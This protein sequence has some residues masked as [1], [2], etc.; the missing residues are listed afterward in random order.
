[1][2]VLLFRFLFL[3]HL[4]PHAIQVPFNSF[5]LLWVFFFLFFSPFFAG[6]FWNLILKPWLCC[7]VLSFSRTFLRKHASR[8]EVSLHKDF[9]VNTQNSLANNWHLNP[10][11]ESIPRATNRGRGHAPNIAL[12]QWFLAIKVVARHNIKQTWGYCKLYQRL[13]F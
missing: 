8:M 5:T 10:I 1:M 11:L 7:I 9:K 12:S 3:H 4:K 6:I 13:G 2:S